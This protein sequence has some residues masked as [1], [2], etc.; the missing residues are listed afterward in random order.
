V[1][2]VLVLAFCHLDISGV[3]LPS[4]L[5]LTVA[6]LSCKPVCLYFWETSSLQEE[7]RY[8]ELWYRVISGVQIETRRILF[9]TDPW[10]LCPGGS[11]RVPLGPGV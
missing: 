1:A 10:F 11:G 7:F 4:L 6:S 8:G 9:P 2:Y 3:S 5:S